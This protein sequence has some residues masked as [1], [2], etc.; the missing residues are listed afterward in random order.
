MGHHDGRSPGR[1]GRIYGGPEISG[2]RGSGD[3]FDFDLNCD[4]LRAL[5]HI[6]WAFD[7]NFIR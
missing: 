4:F 2:F 5:S 7:L 3:I 6:D 1:C